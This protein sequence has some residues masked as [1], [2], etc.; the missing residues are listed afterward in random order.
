MRLTVPPF[1]VDS[2]RLPG[3]RVYIADHFSPLHDFGAQI[4]LVA[5]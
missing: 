4:I 5:L 2:G 1:D 3:A